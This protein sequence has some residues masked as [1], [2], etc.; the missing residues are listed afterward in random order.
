MIHDYCASHGHT[1][2]S[3]TCYTHLKCFH[4]HPPACLDWTEICNGKVHC[5]EGHY[6]EGYCWQLELVGNVHLTL[7]RNSE[8]FYEY[9]VVQLVFGYDDRICRD[10]FITSSCIL[11]H[12]NILKESMFSV[13]QYSVSDKCWMVCKCNFAIT[14]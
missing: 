5:L 1:T 8:T 10:L 4:G 7:D 14:T 2:T 6:D 13:K 11:M 3:L 9:I 12:Q